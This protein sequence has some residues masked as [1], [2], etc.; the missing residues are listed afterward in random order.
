MV[1]YATNRQG[2]IGFT[3][4]MFS[5][6]NIGNN[7]AGAY[8]EPVFNEG[9]TVSKL[10]QSFQWMT[11]LGEGEGD[12][13]AETFDSA[14][15]Y[16]DRYCSG[17][18]TITNNARLIEESW[19]FNDFRNLILDA[20]LG[21]PFFDDEGELIADFTIAK[22]WYQQQ[23]ISGPYAAIRLIISPDRDITLYLNEALAKFRISSR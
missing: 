15:I 11:R 8:I 14:I 6:I 1:A 4:A 7:N 21:N 16:N 12:W 10:F 20:N 9:G 22:P 19:N 13:Q 18:R 5:N 23:R 2:F 3:G 17:V